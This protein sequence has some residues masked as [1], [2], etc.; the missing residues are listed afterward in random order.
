MQVDVHE[1]ELKGA[2]VLC[3]QLSGSATDQERLDWLEQYRQK[4]VTSQTNGR[5]VVSIVDLTMAPA[6][7]PQQRRAQA[8]WNKLNT[9]LLR[10]VQLFLAFVAPSALIRGILTAVWWFNPP[11]S[12]HAICATLTEALNQGFDACERAGV[13]VPEIFRRE[14]RRL[15]SGQSSVPSA[16]A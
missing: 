14:G 16:R 1:F 2:L 3:T 5:L 15:F 10:E 8:D 9:V 4:L 12:P 13:R 11:P 6:L 7:T